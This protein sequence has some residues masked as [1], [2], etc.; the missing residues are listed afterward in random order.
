MPRITRKKI[1]DEDAFRRQ[2]K[3][4]GLKLTPQRLAVHRTMIEL[5]HASADMVFEKLD[6]KLKISRASIYNTLSELADKGIYSR[7]YSPDSKMYFDV[8]PSRHVHLF[9]TKN[10]EFLDVGDLELI[11][12]VES[13]LKGK[14]FRGYKMDDIEIQIICH[15]TRKKLL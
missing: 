12:L 7:R 11:P 13:G 1:Q 3:N 8:D 4:L 10:C 9:D 6:G 15:P 5:V 2:L 14:R